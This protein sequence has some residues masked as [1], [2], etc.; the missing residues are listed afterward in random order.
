LVRRHHGLARE[1]AKPLLGRVGIVN[2][3]RKLIS[4]RRALVSIQLPPTGMAHCQQTVQKCRQPMGMAPTL[5][6]RCHNQVWIWRVE[7]EPLGTSSAGQTALRAVVRQSNS[8]YV[9]LGV[10]WQVQILS[11]RPMS[12]RPIKHTLSCCD[13]WWA[14]RRSGHFGI[15]TP[16]HTPTRICCPNDHR[17]RSALKPSTAVRASIRATAASEGTISINPCVIRGAGTTKRKH[18]R[19]ADLATTLWHPHIVSVRRRGRNC[20]HRTRQPGRAAVDDRGAAGP[21]A[22]GSRPRRHLRNAPLPFCRAET[23]HTNGNATGTIPSERHCL[24]IDLDHCGH[25]RR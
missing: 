13:L 4:C 18:N 24:T 19:E 22:S 5:S 20:R 23:S 25:S 8:A 21:L 15:N 11:A 1:A 3:N 10:K 9:R 7:R 16:T 6:Q 14:T 2:G 17:P 12:A